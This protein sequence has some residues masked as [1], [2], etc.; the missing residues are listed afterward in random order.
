MKETA[1]GKT[2]KENALELKRII[3]GLMGVIPQ[4]KKMDVGLDIRHTPTSYEVGL[5]SEFDNMED[6]KIYV[7][8]P[9]HKKVL[10]FIG[11]TVED[12]KVVDWE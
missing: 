3:D 5:Y 6:L 7:D 11:Q 10:E 8:H 1:L 2:G 4:L 9:A 12:R